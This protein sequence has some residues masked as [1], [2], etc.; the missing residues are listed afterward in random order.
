M[1]LNYAEVINRTKTVGDKVAII[2]AGGIGFDVAEFLL[3]KDHQQKI[4]DWYDEWGI[5]PSFESRGSL[6]TASPDVSDRD[7]VLM[8]RK[9]GRLG[10]GL[11]KTSG[12]VHRAQ[13]K[14]KNVRMIPAVAYKKI[15]DQRMTAL[16][17]F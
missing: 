10:N 17:K 9:P 6:V 7:I 8:Q 1:V 3:H 2:G 13:L 4:V 16:M 11:G 14:K 5:D 12:W 15:D